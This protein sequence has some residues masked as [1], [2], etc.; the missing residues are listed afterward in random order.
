MRKKKDRKEE[1]GEKR[2]K[3]RGKLIKMEKETE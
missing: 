2:Q 1:G 3:E